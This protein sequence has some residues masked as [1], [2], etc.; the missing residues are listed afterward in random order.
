MKFYLQI[1]NERSTSMLPKVNFL[2]YI[3]TE[4]NTCRQNRCHQ[5]WRRFV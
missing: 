1:K 4:R 5:N 3:L 2:S